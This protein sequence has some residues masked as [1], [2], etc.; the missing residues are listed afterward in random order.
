[1]DSIWG[2]EPCDSGSNPGAFTTRGYGVMDSI[3]FCGV[4][5][6]GSN[7]G[8]PTTKKSNKNNWR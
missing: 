4:V 5:D 8:T 6:P 1:M 3:T 2:F 7:P